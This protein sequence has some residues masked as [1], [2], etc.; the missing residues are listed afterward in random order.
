VNKSIS[1]SAFPQRPRPAGSGQPAIPALIVLFSRQSTIRPDAALPAARSARCRA[2][3]QIHL[4]NPF[5]PGPADSYQVKVAREEP[6]SFP[7]APGE[8][9]FAPLTRHIDA[10]LRG[11]QEPRLLDTALPTA[12]ALHKLAASA[13]QHR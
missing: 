6:S 11:E 1:D 7:A 9:S 5:H 2:G 4:T 8:L 3:G 12:Q 10:V 13:G